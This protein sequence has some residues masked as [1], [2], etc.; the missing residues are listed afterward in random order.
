M[1][2]IS[3]YLKIPEPQRHQH[4]MARVGHLWNGRFDEVVLVHYLPVNDHLSAG[5]SQK[6]RLGHSML[7][8][9]SLRVKSCHVSQFLCLL[10]ALKGSYEVYDLY[11]Y[12]MS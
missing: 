5:E 7:P 11:F 8:I 2:Q 4:S 6:Y 3:T 12:R 9:N 1:K 10:L